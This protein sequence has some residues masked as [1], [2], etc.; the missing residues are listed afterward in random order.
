M[1]EALL[2]L[3]ESQPPGRCEGTRG[4]RGRSHEDR[5]ERFA[6]PLSG[7]QAGILLRT[8]R[9]DPTEKTMIARR[10]DLEHPP[11]Q[12]RQR[13]QLALVGIIG[14][15]RAERAGL[16]A[17]ATEE[18]ALGPLA[19]FARKSPSSNPP[20]GFGPILLGGG[21]FHLGRPT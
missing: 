4:T 16:R 19:F 10:T 9:R 3:Y 5:I 8:Y 13:A 20:Q 6:D 7:A 12:L 18:Q 17:A 1:L 2:T 15:S 21:H 11:D 14:A